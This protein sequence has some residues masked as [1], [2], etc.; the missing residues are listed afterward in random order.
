MSPSYAGVFTSSNSYKLI[1]S[2]GER[3][4]VAGALT[5]DLERKKKLI[6]SS[7]GLIPLELSI[8]PIPFR[9]DFLRAAFHFFLLH[10]L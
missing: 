4:L 8:D 7:R 6:S 9:E 3:D 1:N 5:R 2:R 10:L